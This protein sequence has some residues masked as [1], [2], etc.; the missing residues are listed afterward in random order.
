M[1]II[2]AEAIPFR[3]P[4]KQLF[5]IAS[6]TLTHTNHVIVRMT[7]DTGRVGWGETT[8]FHSVYGYDQKSLYH[9]LKDHLIPAV[10]GM[11][12]TDMA[13][14]HR[15]MDLAI[16][17]NLMAK[18]GIDLAAYDLS[19]QAAN[20]PLS[21]IIGSQR[22]NRIP[23][24]AAIGITSL[25]ETAAQAKSYVE[26]GFKVLKAKIGLHADEDLKRLRAI[27][28][29]VGEEVLLRVD[30]NQGYNLPTAISLLDPLDELNLEWIE[31]P[32]PYWD[33]DGL[34]TLTAM[35]RTPIAVDESIYTIHDATQIISSS[36]A[37]VINIKVV[38]CGGIYRSQQ[39]AKYCEEQNVR[40]FLGGCLETAPG[41]IAQCHFFAST[42]NLVSATEMG[43]NYFVDDIV[44]TPIQTE[45]DCFILPKGPGLGVIVDQEKLAAYRIDF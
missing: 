14:L 33:R 31:Q 1:K 23:T 11:D 29:A 6:G 18:C 35:S 22:T 30:A 37:N 15:R 32:L 41:T 13:A 36:I 26:R 16:P 34:K 38:K 40:C 8:T 12:P 3:I 42:P 28:K 2:S 19:A 21:E 17:F 45:G 25:E 4:L 24:I 7:D 5:S 44:Q 43:G 9:V 20:L 27:R 39:I 10:I